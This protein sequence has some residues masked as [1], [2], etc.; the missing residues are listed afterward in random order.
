LSNFWLQIGLGE[1]ICIVLQ[2]IVKIS[3]KAAQTSRLTILKMAAVRHFEFFDN[4]AFRTA[5]GV[6]IEGL[7]ASTGNI[8]SKSIVTCQDI[9]IYPSAILDL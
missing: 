2:N 6:R 7:C 1:L 5:V 4:F 9:A 8:K 3:P